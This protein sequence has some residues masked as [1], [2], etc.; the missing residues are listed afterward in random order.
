MAKA[1]T[2][3]RSLARNHTDRAL[4]VLQGIMDQPDA[5]HAA[6]VA[7]ANSLLDR[8][9]GKPTQPIAGDDDAD[10]I[11]TVTR[12]ERAIVDPANQDG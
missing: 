1:L 9:W 10:P 4:Q 3:I 8:G 7:A 2:H 5:P 11:R 12:I 6:R